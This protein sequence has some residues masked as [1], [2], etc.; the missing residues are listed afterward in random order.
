MQAP[1][2]VR[3]RVFVSYSHD[4]DEHMQAVRAL[5]ER[6]IRLGC[7]CVLDQYESHP[8]KGW[9]QWMDRQLDEADFVLVVCTEGYYRKAKGKRPRAGLGVRFESVLIV[10]DLYDAGMWN[11][12]FIPVLLHELPAELILRPLR[13]FNHYRLDRPE[14]FEELL[15][16]L[17][18]QPRYLRPAP[19]PAPILASDPPADPERLPEDRGF[20]PAAG[21]QARGETRRMD[22]IPRLHNLPSLSLGELFAGRDQDLAEIDAVL[23]EERSGT[24][25]SRHMVLHGLGGI[26]KTQLAVEH[27]WRVGDR[28][29]AVFFVRAESPEG[30]QAEIAGLAGVELLDLP[31][32][33]ERAESEVAGAVLRWLRE[34]PGWLLII[35]NAD[36]DEAAQA[37]ME[38][39][40]RLQGGHVLITSRIAVWPAGV[41]A[42]EVVRIDAASAVR[43]LLERTQGARATSGDDELVAARLSERLGG[44]PLALEQAAAY[45]GYHRMT[46]GRYLAEWDERSAA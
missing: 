27:A 19:G 28:Y 20:G 4:S 36:S 22:G 43:L 31:A 6:L 15:R 42:R 38:L 26:G 8:A 16:H 30:L 39:L 5:A 45:V 17:T 25:A 18:G 9:A 37:V 1:V 32:R 12:R 44:L 3:P 35:D 29:R 40:P 46:L 14:S 11:E 2:L 33:R 21:R 41:A 34:N 7:D 24:W 13:G 23:G 10:Q